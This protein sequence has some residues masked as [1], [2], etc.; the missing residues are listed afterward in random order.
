MEWLRKYTFPVES[1]YKDL[2][3]ACYRYPLLVK[4][5]LVS[6]CDAYF[7]RKEVSVFGGTGPDGLQR[8]PIYSSNGRSGRSAVH[9]GRLCTWA[10]CMQPS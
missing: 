8:S 10:C 4:R 5:F 2:D 1:S 3:A 6:P 9:M 7:D